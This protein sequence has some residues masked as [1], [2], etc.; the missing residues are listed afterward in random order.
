MERIPENTLLVT[1]GIVVITRNPTHFK[2]EYDVK[3]IHIKY[4]DIGKKPKMRQNIHLQ[5]ERERE[6]H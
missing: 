6:K 3:N 1:V 4:G 5:R 2:E